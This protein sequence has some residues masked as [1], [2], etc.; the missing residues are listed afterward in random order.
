MVYEDM[1][2]ES[3][4]SKEKYFAACDTIVYLNQVIDGLKI[5]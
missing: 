2:S 1:R 3:V 5:A 4:K